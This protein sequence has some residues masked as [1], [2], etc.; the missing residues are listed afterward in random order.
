MF[1]GIVAAVGRIV[2]LEP[3]GEAVR[4]RIDVGTLDL[5]DVKVGDSISVDGVC[6]TATALEATHFECDVSRA[7]LDCTAGMSNGAEVNLEKALRMGDRLDGHLVSGHV[8]GVAEVLRFDPAGENRRLILRAPADLAKFIARKGSISVQGVSLTV[9]AVQDSEFEVNLIPHTLAATNLRN[10]R[11]GVR[12]NL[13]VD[14][15][16][17]Y[18]ERMLN[19]E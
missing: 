2:H 17:R 7:T 5:G 3:R 9:N 18:V 16:A 19:R 11:P 4:A 10:L 12:V 1:T 8:D 6:L 14:Q 15:L 13:E